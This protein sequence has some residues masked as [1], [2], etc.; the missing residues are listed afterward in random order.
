MR[1][2]VGLTACEP[3]GRSSTEPV[4]PSAS[5]VV[6]I[7]APPL[8][9]QPVPSKLL[10]LWPGASAYQLL[11]CQDRNGCES[12]EWSTSTCRPAS[13]RHARDSYDTCEEDYQGPHHGSGRRLKR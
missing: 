13:S 9:T 1:Q 3:L 10:A 12:G 7:L 8:S 4:V 5:V 6:M 2:I 11:S